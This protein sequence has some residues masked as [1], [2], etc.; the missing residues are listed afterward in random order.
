MLINNL[1]DAIIEEC[2]NAKK[3]KLFGTQEFHIEDIE[4]IENKDGAFNFKVTT[5]NECST[6]SRKVREMPLY[7][8]MDLLGRVIGHRAINT[9]YEMGFIKKSS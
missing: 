8:V 4:Q 1:I 7:E 6:D 5:W 3:Y 9:S 2:H